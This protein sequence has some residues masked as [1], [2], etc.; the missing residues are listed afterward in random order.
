MASS[1][2][3]SG[4]Q[5]KENAFEEDGGDDIELG[6]DQEVVV[7]DPPRSNSRRRSIG[8]SYKVLGREPACLLR[9]V[10][11]LSCLH[12]NFFLQE[13][14]LNTKLRKGHVFFPKSDTP[15]K[16]ASGSTKKPAAERGV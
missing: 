7:I 8:I 3:R 11:S 14:S 6:D 15:F 4:G 2:R 5:G 1:R 10:W 9:H 13:P 16:G 12:F